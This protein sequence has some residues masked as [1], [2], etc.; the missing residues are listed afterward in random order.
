MINE[1]AKK[2]SPYIEIVAEAWDKELG[3]TNL[4]LVLMNLLAEKFNALPERSGKPDVRTNVRAVRRLFK[5]ALKAK[6]VLSANKQA[7][8][9]VPEL[10]DYVTLFTTIERSEFEEVA[11][12]FF[13]KVTKPIEE[14]L[15]KAGLTVD[16]I[17]QVEIIGGGVRTP[18]VF[19]LLEAYVKKDLNVHLN[20][21]EAMCFGSSFIATNSSS[22]FKVK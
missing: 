4:D 2:S 9:K 5:D 18:K 19:E 7:V 6:E 15:A 22:K 16:D 10:L 1:T 3:S 20:G 11:K 8:I 13:S 17:D 21:D 14:A 12:D